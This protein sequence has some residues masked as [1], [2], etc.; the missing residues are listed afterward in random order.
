MLSKVKLLLSITDETQDDLISLLVDMAKEEATSFCHLPE[1]D[2]SLDFI[3]IKMVVQNYNKIGNEGFESSSFGG[4]MTE[5]Y[6]TNY[7]EDVLTALKK[8]RKLISL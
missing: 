6:I 3:V 8:H 4:V 2:T 1:Y 7:S 5:N